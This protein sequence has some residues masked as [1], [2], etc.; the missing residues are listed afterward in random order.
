MTRVVQLSY[1]SYLTYSAK[2]YELVGILP[3]FSGC[4]VK[5]DMVTFKIS[6]SFDG[7]TVCRR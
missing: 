3:E 7:P 6:T 5:P 4:N 1:L 2:N